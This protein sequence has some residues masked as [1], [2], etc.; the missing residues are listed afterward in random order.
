MKKT[1]ILV[2]DDE[3][4]MRE[5]YEAV[6][7]TADLTTVGAKNA[8]EAL[9]I[10]NSSPVQVM[11]L[12]LQLPG[13]NG[14]ELCRKIK[15]LKPTAVCIAVTGNSSIFDLVACREAGFDDYFA[16]PVPVKDLIAAAQA[17]FAK[18]ERWAAVMS[19]S[20]RVPAQ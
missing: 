20:E 11:F 2:V 9:E 3:Q 13:M 18:V 12:D 19:R 15:T 7:S 8:E 4:S 1:S 10:I 16:K 14:V 17:S 5:M 6:L